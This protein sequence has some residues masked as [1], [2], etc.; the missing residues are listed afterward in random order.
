MPDFC[1]NC[2]ESLGSVKD[3]FKDREEQLTVAAEEYTGLISEL[4]K[5]LEACK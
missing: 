5:R 3:E 4:Q 1:F 2:R